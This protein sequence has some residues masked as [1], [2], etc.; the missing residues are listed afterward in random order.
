[1]RKM[2]SQQLCYYDKQ[3][4]SAL[5]IWGRACPTRSFWEGEKLSGCLPALDEATE[6]QNEHQGLD[7]GVHHQQHVQHTGGPQK[8]LVILSPCIMIFNCHEA[9]LHSLTA[10]QMYVL[11]SCRQYCMACKL[12]AYTASD[13]SDIQRWTHCLESENDVSL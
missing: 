1:M 8:S 2:T 3:K 7:K 11:G 13:K 9:C 6:E 5:C 10:G 4:A 12:H